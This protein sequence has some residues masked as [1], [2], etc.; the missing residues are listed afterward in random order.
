M[1]ATSHYA[2]E[3]S[4]EG[5]ADHLGSAPRMPVHIALARTSGATQL[6]RA[7]SGREM[8]PH[9]HER[10][11]SPAWA[12]AQHAPVGTSPVSRRPA[13]PAD[14]H[15]LSSRLARPLRRRFP[16]CPLLRRSRSQSGS[17]DR[18]L[19]L[20]AVNEYYCTATAIA[21]APCLHKTG[22]PESVVHGVRAVHSG[23]CTLPE[24]TR[25]APPSARMTSA[26]RPDRDVPD[27]PQTLTTTEVDLLRLLARVEVSP[28]SGGPTW[29][30]PGP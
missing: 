22:D 20:T 19:E 15:D 12:A 29:P 18:A 6:L 5:D 11:H 14:Q 23:A 1:R 27:L 13:A 4:R 9:S 10:C 30:G 3:P 16:R 28:R 2:H 8:V 26:D 24:P 25:S 7:P 21:A 17:L